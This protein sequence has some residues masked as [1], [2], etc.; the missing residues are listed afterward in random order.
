MTLLFFP[1]PDLQAELE[2]CFGDRVIAGLSS[3]RKHLDQM[4]ASLAENEVDEQT[5]EQ[6]AVELMEPPGN[7]AK[8]KRKGKGKSRNR[9]TGDAE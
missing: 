2:A 3:I 8:P 7:T 5:E 1:N 6:P 4:I 9:K